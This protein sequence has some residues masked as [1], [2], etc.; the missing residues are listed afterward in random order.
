MKNS[1][2]VKPVHV[3]WAVSVKVCRPENILGW[4]ECADKSFS[5]EDILENGFNRT[6]V[7]IMEGKETADYECVWERKKFEE[8]FN[9]RMENKLT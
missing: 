6:V 8:R 9:K 4:V 5:I 7:T 1:G 3:D 2:T